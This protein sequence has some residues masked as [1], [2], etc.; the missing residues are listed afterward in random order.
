ML[1]WRSHTVAFGI[2]ATGFLGQMLVFR[3]WGFPM[4]N[5]YIFSCYKVEVF[6]QMGLKPTKGVKNKGNSKR[7]TRLQGYTPPCSL[8]NT[9]SL[10]AGIPVL[11]H[12][13]RFWP[14]GGAYLTEGVVRRGP[15][16]WLIFWDFLCFLLP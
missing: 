11:D 13:S 8:L 5:L 2:S 16:T 7:L 15:V 3:L 1:T 4:G 12:I 9:S 14:K 10:L 6:G